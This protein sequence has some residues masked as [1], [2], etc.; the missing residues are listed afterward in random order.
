M[1]FFLRLPIGQYGPVSQLT[2]LSTTRELSCTGPFNWGGAHCAGENV[3]HS[4]RTIATEVSSRKNKQTANRA[5]PA[6]ATRNPPAR[7]PGTRAKK[8]HNKP[9]ETSK[10]DPGTP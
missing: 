3:K 7:L 2:V 10:T 8:Q 1:F 4:D 5:R 9:Q 6:T